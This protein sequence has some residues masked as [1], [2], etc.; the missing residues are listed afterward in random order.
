MIKKIYTMKIHIKYISI[1]LLSLIVLA[2][3]TKDFEEINTNPHGFT[4][5][6]DGSLFNGVIQRLTPKGNESFYINSEILYK[7]TQMLALTK[8]AWGNYTLGTEE[9]WGNYYLSLPNIRELKKRFEVM[10]PSEEL[11]NMKA[12]I[13]IVLAYQTFK[14]TDMFGDIPFFHAGYG[15]QTT[16]YLHPEYDTQKSIYIYLLEELKWCDEHINVDAVK[17]EPFKT[18]ATFDALFHGDMLLY[19]KLANSL[20][21]RYAMR[22]SGKEEEKAAEIVRDIVEN[23]RP[24]LLG[25]DFTTYVGES[26]CLWPAQMGFTNGATDWAFY[27]HKNL[28]VGS[29]VWHLIS[30]NDNTNGDGIFDPRAYI[31]FEPNNTNQWVAYPQ[32]PDNNTPPSGGIPYGT[33][34]DG[35]ATFAVKGETNIYSFVNYFMHRDYNN[36]P[37]PMIT[38]SEVHFILAEAYM[39]GIGVAQDP[40]QADIEYMNGINS[41]VEWW[42]KVAENS[43]LP[44]SK[45]EFPDMIHIPEGIN[46]A[47]VLN[48]WGSWNAPTDEDRLKFIYTQRILDAFWQ[49]W[50]AYALARRTN[51]TPRE[52]GPINHFRLPYP[53]SEQEFNSEM[54]MKA[55]QNQGGDSPQDKIWWINY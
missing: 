19:Q 13:K 7:Q 29:N 28:R 54:M 15:F 18:F 46:A 38:G 3:C 23:E 26:A 44:L 22:M 25:Y 42:M 14:I 31:F 11:N 32:I 50:E 48:V 6:S 41:S 4:L 16:E 36:M 40:E 34:R 9:S 49:P 17:Q 20:R 27:E 2:S 45:L 12:M 52:G 30:S 37:I 39:K 53:P 47:T 51:M 55:I 21:L 10:E 24:I 8:S 43:V 1:V 5:A 33:H 35:V